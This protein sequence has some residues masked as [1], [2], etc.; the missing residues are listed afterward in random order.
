M[1]PIKVRVRVRV[2]VRVRVLGLVMPQGIEDDSSN[3]GGLL[4][5]FVGPPE[6]DPI[7]VRNM[8]TRLG[9]SVEVVKGGGGP[10]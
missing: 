4:F 10:T 8:I 2:S 1:P 7:R 9:I 6:H 3:G 5:V